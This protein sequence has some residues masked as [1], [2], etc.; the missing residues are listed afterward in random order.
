VYVFALNLKH[1]RS[2]QDLWVFPNKSVNVIV[3][4]NNSGKTS[5]LRALA[6][7]LDPTVNL[8]QPDVI[9]R[10]DFHNI[11]L[12]TPIELYLWLKPR[13]REV[14][15]ANGDIESQYVE[16]GEI[17]AAFFD[18][19]SQWQVE[20]V[21]RLDHTGAEEHHPSRLVPIAV[22]PM[23]AEMPE[24]ESL[25]AIRLRG[26]WNSEQEAVDL[27]L[28]VVDQM[29]NEIAPLGFRQRELLGFK[30]LG[31]R[32]NPLRELSLSRRSVLSQMLD[33]DEVTSA[34]RRILASLDDAKGPLLEQES[35]RDLMARLG[36]LVAPEF[37]G[38]L[39]TNLGNAFTLTFL[40]GDLWRLR[41]ATSI[42]TTVGLSRDEVT[43]LPLEYQGD[44]AQ[45]LILLFHLIELLRQGGT[46]SIIA[47]EEPEQ[48][49]EPT[50]AR[51]VFGELCSLSDDAEDQQGQ[52]F[53]TTHSPALVSEL[54][55]ADSLLLF[56]ER[57]TDG[58]NRPEV[59]KWRV[60]SGQH[61]SQDLRKKLDQH[62]ERYVSALFARQVLIVEGLSEVG[63][64]PVAFRHFAMGSAHQNPYHL[65]LEVMNGESKSQA[66]T[67][68]KI[69]GGYGRK[70]H[71]LL[72]YD[73]PNDD[74]E[75]LRSRFDGNVDFVTCWPNVN[76]LDFAVGCDL[77][78]ILA[79]HVPPAI[80]FAALKYA[81]S[82]AG[83][84]LEK[85]SWAKACDLITDRE[86]VGGFPPIYDD[87]DLNTINL[88][89]L[90][91]ERVQ[92]AFLF[93]LLHGPHSCKSAKDMRMIAAL[94]A[95]HNAFPPIVDT[96][97]QKVLVSILRPQEIDHAQPYL[98]AGA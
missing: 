74:A 57:Q 9:S 38:A 11:D 85:D 46:N 34:L 23:E 6:L 31:S 3:G 48:N 42:A 30:M 54:K 92:R 44:G 39:M 13:V 96:L 84:A 20:N 63:F 2:F 19:F 88:E 10:F 16:D 28:S 68:A 4:P 26:V 95:E 14:T 89:T 60:I 22:D 64:L 77:E 90:G 41:G 25:L 12:G 29:D 73:G 83:H 15:L 86:I 1:F 7:M 53:I 35:V 47:L 76:L 78:V 69:L 59:S 66:P 82:D 65:G 62:R 45:N 52:V 81:Y 79:A 58:D 49:L 21:H 8:G 70:C 61:L 5:V 80:L 36:R 37:L 56:S 91:D 27:E 43:P 32:R 55:G 67:H 93:A 51:C 50:L 40:S 72:D 17:I 75:V 98:A 94:L 71:L 33:E 24:H 18:K 97:R 87:A